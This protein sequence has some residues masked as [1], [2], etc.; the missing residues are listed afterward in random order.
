MP[1]R[2]KRRAACFS[3]MTEEHP[4]APY[5]RI[6]GKGPHLSRA[7]TE[8]EMIEAAAQAAAQAMWEK[9]DRK[10]FPAG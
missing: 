10:R 2:R 7:Q 4:F 3:G 8:D 9:R 6:I 5:V 1:A